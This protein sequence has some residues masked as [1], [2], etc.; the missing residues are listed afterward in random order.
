MPNFLVSVYIPTHNRPL[1]LQR[2]LRSVQKQDYG[3]IEIIVVDDGSTPQAQAQNRLICQ[4]YAN[5]TL[6]QFQQSKGAGAARNAAIYCA[7]GEFI[8][9]LDDDDEFLP[10]R[11]SDFVYTWRRLP[12]LS[13]LCTGYEFVLPGGNHIRSGK[14]AMWIDADRIRHIN[15][16]GNQ[17]FTRTS[18][19]KAIGGFDPQLVACQDYDV[20][21]RLISAYGKAYRL[22][23]QNYLVHQE[24]EF[25]RISTFNKRLQGHQQLIDKHQDQLTTAQLKSQRF[26]R[27]L[28][29]G[30]QNV[31]YLLRLAGWRHSVVLL[32]ML[33]ARQLTRKPATE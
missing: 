2:A 26:F 7:K 25:P 16:V 19:L 32:K 23:K 22:D 5:V 10:G 33:L 31:W 12:G 4:G 17:V 15:D 9:G 30:E 29:G 6:L 24:H 11:I 1:L 18:Y 20:W 14:K 21:I 28:Y 27:L 13:L 8:T 3:A